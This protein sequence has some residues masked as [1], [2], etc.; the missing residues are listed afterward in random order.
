L[1][2]YLCFHAT[3][4]KVLK[5]GTRKKETW[6]SFSG[7]RFFAAELKLEYFKTRQQA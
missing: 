6:N 1:A 5:K 2:A 4:R 3:E 7:R